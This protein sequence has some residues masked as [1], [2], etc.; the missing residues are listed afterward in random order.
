MPPDAETNG[1]DPERLLE[2]SQQSIGKVRDL[3]DELKIVHQ[4]ESSLLHE[5]TL[6]EDEPPLFR[7]IR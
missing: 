4:H 3:A 2:E 7:P 1:P 6:L 5:S